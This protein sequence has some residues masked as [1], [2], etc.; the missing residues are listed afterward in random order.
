MD[1]ADDF[2]NYEIML[3]ATGRLDQ[4]NNKLVRILERYTEYI[5]ARWQTRVQDVRE[6]GR[7]PNVEYVIKRVAEEKNDSVFCGT[8]DSRNRGGETNQQ[9]SQKGAKLQASTE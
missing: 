7:E 1:L 4:V 2:Q 3:R 9:N 6:E 5:R 8:M